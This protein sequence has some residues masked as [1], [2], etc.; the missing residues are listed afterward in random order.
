M[1]YKIVGGAHY[2]A[3]LDFLTD[4]GFHISKELGKGGDTVSLCQKEWVCHFAHYKAP[5]RLKGIPA[6]F[7]Y[8]WPPCVKGAPA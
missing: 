3:P 4:K 2:K 8:F 7:Q 6:N 1:K 5:P